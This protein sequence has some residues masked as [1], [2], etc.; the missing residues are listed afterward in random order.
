[1]VSKELKS[2][3]LI[4][5]KP[6][7]DKGI[8]LIVYHP[9]NPDKRLNLQIKGRGAKQSNKRYRW[10]QLRTS[11]A[12]RE[13][14]PDP[15]D[16]WRMKVEKCDFFL[17]VSLYYDEV[18][19]FP[20]KQVIELIERNQVVYGHRKNN[21]RGEQVEMDLDIQYEGTPLT[22]LYKENKNNFMLIMKKLE[23]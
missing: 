11:K 3:G 13:R 23:E 4:A 6:I 22:E 10:F 12:Q 2:L 15:K 7:P 5:R 8:D 14:A 19:V 16:A 18:W 1:M 9:D 20:Q 21:I 17:L